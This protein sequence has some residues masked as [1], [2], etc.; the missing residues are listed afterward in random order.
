MS[1]KLL[2]SVVLVLG[3]ASSPALACKGA[4][5][6]LSDEFKGEMDPAWE[7]L[8]GE[9]TAKDGKLEVKTDVGKIGLMEYQGD[10]FPGADVCVDIVAPSTKDAPS[11]FAG[12]SFRTSKGAYYVGI[13]PDGSAGVLRY[14][15]GW[16]KP[17]PVRKFDA[18]NTAVG[19]TNSLRVVWKA[20]DTSVQ[21][22]VNDR[23]FIAFKSAEANDTRK[24]GIYA[25]SEGNTLTYS[26][27]KVTSPPK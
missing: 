20:G 16:L 1:L 2:A 24:I 18:V 26:N 14:F 15:K 17:V 6:L 8:N 3:V 4:Q 10:F 21:T 27:F 9:F 23:P 25:E 19:A 7:I 12:I 22:F 13:R 11:M 5:V